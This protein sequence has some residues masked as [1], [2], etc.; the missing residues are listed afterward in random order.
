MFTYVYIYGVDSMA[1]TYLS[2]IRV[3]WLFQGKGLYSKSWFPGALK[4]HLVKFRLH[5]EILP[6]QTWCIILP[7][8][9]GSVWTH[10]GGSWRLTFSYI[11]ALSTPFLISIWYFYAFATFSYFNTILLWFCDLFLDI[12]LVWFCHLFFFAYYITILLWFCYL[13]SFGYYI[14]FRKGSKMY[15]MIW[16]WFNFWLNPLRVS[17]LIGGRWVF[18]FRFSFGLGLWTKLHWRQ[19]SLLILGLQICGPVRQP[20]ADQRDCRPWPPLQGKAQWIKLMR[21]ASRSEAN[22]LAA[23]R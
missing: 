9:E 14:Y 1:Y 17:P 16:Y 11:L 22:L 8:D 3:M 5:V 20:A 19:I 7:L 21:C 2:F 12:I 15:N 18:V 13:F 4:R 6:T 10:F 23:R